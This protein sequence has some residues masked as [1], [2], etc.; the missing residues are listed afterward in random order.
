MINSFVRTFGQTLINSWN[1][2]GAMNLRHRRVGVV[3]IVLIVAGGLL[4]AFLNS[5][6]SSGSYVSTNNSALM[7][8]NGDPTILLQNSLHGLGAAASNFLPAANSAVSS[9]SSSLSPPSS[10][11]GS[12][13]GSTVVLNTNQQTGAASTAQPRPPANTGRSVEF[14]SNVSLRVSSPSSALDRASAA[15]Y[16]LGG[17]VAYST[18]M[19]SSAFVVLRVPAQN[20]REALIQVESLGTVVG[21]VSTSN[22]VTVQY[23][24]LNAT[25]A[26]LTAEQT[27]LLRLLNQSTSI[28][29]TLQIESILQGVNA[30]MN[31]VQSEILQ[32]QRLINYGTISVSLEKLAIVAPPRPL[33]LKLTAS[34]RSGLSPLSVTFNAI[35]EGGS[36]QYIVNYNFGDGTSSQGQTLIHTFDQ[37]GDYNVTVTATD[38]T[39]NVSEAWTTIKVTSPPIASGFG[40]FPSFVGGLFIQVIEGI[41]EV[42]VVVLPLAAIGAMVVLPFRRR[43]GPRQKQDK[44]QPASK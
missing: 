17:Y 15:A 35:A 3:L 18:I 8:S 42:A 29:S 30:H 12:I 10:A 32:T 24:D 13:Q 28:N 39:G 36:T 7:S 2:A 16:S 21:A 25:L 5:S 22:D 19:N 27:S 38:S 31:E 9:L 26:S 34:P 6:F 20:Y 43:F 14:F 23:T 11:V 41:I 1:V 44:A 37:P 40:N 33:T 4:V